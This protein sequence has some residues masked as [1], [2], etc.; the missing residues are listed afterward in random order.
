[1]IASQPFPPEKGLQSLCLWIKFVLTQ[2]AHRRCKQTCRTVSWSHFGGL[3]A[4]GQTPWQ[5]R[6][7]LQL[8]KY[9]GSYLCLAICLDLPGWV[10]SA[11]TTELIRAA[12]AGALESHHRAQEM[13]CM[14]HL[15]IEARA[16][17]NRPLMSHQR[18]ALSSA[19]KHCQSRVDKLL[20]PGAPRKKEPTLV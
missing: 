17:S 16:P 20:A 8:Q 19:E 2:Q 18:G 13:D 15:A 7:Q 6:P 4:S 11:A 1:M 5:H 14:S 9:G 12:V 3:S 10:T